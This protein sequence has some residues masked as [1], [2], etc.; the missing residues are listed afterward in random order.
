MKKTAL[1]LAIL[2][3]LAIPI[4]VTAQESEGS[5]YAILSP[6]L[7]NLASRCTVRASAMA[8]G[9]ILIV[10]EDFQRALNK[11][12]IGDIKIIS[13]P[14]TASGVLTLSGTAVK[15]GDVISG[16]LLSSLN[17]SPAGRYVTDSEFVFE[18]TYTGCAYTFEL[19]LLS[20]KNRAPQTRM[21]SVGSYLSTFEDLAVFSFL[22]GYDPDGNE[23]EFIIINYPDNGTLSVD[24]AS[25][26]YEYRPSEGFMGDDS[27]SYVV[28]DEYGAYSLSREVKITVE[29]LSDSEIFS[30]MKDSEALAEAINL[31]RSGVMSGSYVGSSL[32]FKPKI[33]ITRAEFIAM[34]SECGGIEAKK[35]VLRTQFYDDEDIPSGYKGVIA[36]AYELGYITGKDIDGK[37]CFLPDEIITRAECA[38]IIDRMLGLENQS[39]I[40][41]ISDTENCPEDAL[42]AVNAL[43][44]AYIL[45]REGA[46]VNAELPL[47]REYAAKLL[48]NVKSFITLSDPS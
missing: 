10:K 19:H 24:K 31:T 30:D 48:F 2:L 40:P 17:F 14:D 28:A 13:L 32:M 12:D 6:G 27:F 5:Q 7:D 15:V 3:L 26:K 45:P 16:D 39:S 11:S 20:E 18:D 46:A 37:L 34:L 44:G 1:I 47:T 33:E 23:I 38:K 8:G 35:N 25:G 29:A 42:A 9:D 43:C 22:P 21:Q 41:V 36:S 4:S